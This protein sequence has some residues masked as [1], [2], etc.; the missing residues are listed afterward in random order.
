MFNGDARQGLIAVQDGGGDPPQYKW[1]VGSPATEIWMDNWVIVEGA[2]NV[3]GAY[4]FI[5]FILDP[6]NSAKD[7]EF[8]GYNT[9]IKGLTDHLPK[10]LP[11]KEIV[12]FTPEELAKMKPGAV[13]SAQDRLVDIYNKVKAKAGG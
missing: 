4:D 9:G 13:N 10:D 11:F 5:N 12:F 8:H 7:L 2:K 1:G 6:K 3:D